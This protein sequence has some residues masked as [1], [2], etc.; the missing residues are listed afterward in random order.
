[1]DYTK[2]NFFWNSFGNIIYLVSQWM[3]TVL[4]PILGGFEDAGILSIAMSVSAIFQ[5]VGL[6]GIRSYQVSDIEG[7]YSDSCYMGLRFLTCGASLLLCLFFSACL[8]YRGGQFLAILLFML[9]RLSDTYSDVLHGIAQKNGRLYLGGISFC[10]KGFGLLMGFLIAYFLTKSLNIGLFFMSSVSVAITLFYDLPMARR[11]SVFK[12]TNPI[13][14]CTKLA[15]E[16]LPLCVYLFLSSTIVTLPKLFLEAEL[17][18]LILGVY[19]SIYAPA[20]LLQAASAYLY[21][22]FVTSFAQ[23]WDQNDRRSFEKLLYRM[24]LLILI[25]S[26][27][28][29]IVAQFLGE[30]ALVLVFGEQIRDYVYLLNPILIVS[31]SV[32]C[33]GLLGVVTIVLRKFKWL[34]GGYGAGFLLCLILTSPAIGMFGVNGASYSL[35]L[36]TVVSC[37]ILFAGCIISLRV[38]RTV[39]AD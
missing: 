35:V 33:L 24:L 18:E 29:L 7:K 28:V 20:M 12:L 36:S 38:D 9:F 1:M 22:P 13:A 30:W 10:L 5:T 17:G 21:T 32:S 19:S 25:L 34:L 8:G 2:R 4:V 39:A 37:I 26:L 3:I 6:F 14:E 16:T 11:L 15:L 23:Y 31:T 27:A